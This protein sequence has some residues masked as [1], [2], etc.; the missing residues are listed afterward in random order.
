MK[1]VIDTN[2]L[3]MA[4]PSRSPYHTIIQTFNRRTYQLIITT[5]VFA[6]YEEILSAKANRVIANIVLG[7][8]LEAPNV[9]AANIYYR[10]QLITTD[11]DD[12]KFTD[13]YINGNADYLVTNDAHFN[14]LKNTDFPKINIK[15]ADE[16]LEILKSTSL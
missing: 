14:V 12:N 9:I 1:V 10:W 13:A 4:L 16:F 2:I 6:E 15:S 3:L 5:P 7:A 8:F 11:P